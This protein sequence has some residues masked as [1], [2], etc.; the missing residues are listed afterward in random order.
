M[1]TIDFNK[2]IDINISI[3]MS[4]INKATLEGF[5]KYHGGKVNNLIE[6]YLQ[7]LKREDNYDIKEEKKVEEKVVEEKVVEEKVVEEKVVEEKVVEE[8]IVKKKVDIG[9]KCIARC[10]YKNGYSRRCTRDHKDGEF[11]KKHRKDYEEG[12]LNFGLMNEKRPTIYI[13]VGPESLKKQKGKEIQWKDKEDESELI[14]YPGISSLDNVKE[15]NIQK[16]EKVEEKTPKK[17]DTPKKVEKSKKVKTPKK[18]DTPKKVEKSKKVIISEEVEIK[19]I[20]DDCKEEICDCKTIPLDII[21][22][23]EQEELLSDDENEYIHYQGV[24]YYYDREINVLANIE[25]YGEVGKWDSE[26]QCIIWN[27]ENDR[28]NHMNH[29]DYSP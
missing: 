5:K 4:S 9:T 11:C 15:S 26:N 10:W 24:T 17:D 18:D 29:P 19:N 16:K 7:S 6:E 25:D 21:D 28:E 3:A 23:K 1:I 22:K 13:G 2:E 20:C 14:Y 12:Q 8:K 27:E